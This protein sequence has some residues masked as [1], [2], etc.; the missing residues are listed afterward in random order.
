MSG[1]ALG[2]LYV[3]EYEALLGFAP[4]ENLHERRTAVY[5]ADETPL[6][7]RRGAYH[8]AIL[9]VLGDRV[10]IDHNGHYSE[11]DKPVSA[12]FWDF[13]DDIALLRT[14]LPACARAQAFDPA[15]RIGTALASAADSPA[16]SHGC[17]SCEMMRLHD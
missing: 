15:A 5:S 7:Q 2:E 14:H 1:R 6:K 13:L 11:R 16:F 10:K 8:L 3:F 9:K 12:Q 4:A 17:A